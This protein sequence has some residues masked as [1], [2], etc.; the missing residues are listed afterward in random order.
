MD[1]EQKVMDATSFWND[2][3]AEGSPVDV[4][5]FLAI[6]L[7]RWPFLLLLAALSCALAVG[8][9]FLVRP[10]FT[11]HAVFLPPT[12]PSN[13][14]S[15]LALILRPPS[16]SIYLGLLVSDSVLTDVIER[17][18]L[19]RIYGARDIDM[20]RQS[21]RSA[22]TVTSDASGFVSLQ[23]TD[24]SPQLAQ[25]I[26]TNFLGALSRLNDR[27]AVSEAAQRRLI[28]QS[29]LEHAKNDLE[30]SE[31][32]LKQAQEKSGV[33]SP[34]AQIRSGL[35]AID[36]SRAQIRGMQV[37]LSA[38][39]QGQTE[40][41]PEVKRARSEIATEEGQLVRL[42]NASGGAQGA[43]LSA[44]QAPAVALKFVQLEREVKYNQVLF[45]V[46]AKQYENAKLQESSAAPGV[47]VV[48]LPQVPLHKSKPSRML[49]AVAGFCAGLFLGLIIV[50]VRNRL[51]VLRKDPARARSLETLASAIS[52]GQLRP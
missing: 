16:S 39:L 23:V 33:V 1:Q 13:S 24:K 28:F 21:L 2:P 32:A 27:L 25:V 52:A 42:E 10:Q 36:V 43:G 37:A 45:D 20:A 3:E 14:D 19:Q 38:L 35:S 49:F 12:P 9:S 15:T 30:A 46:M 48:D 31:V 17:T 50:F 11:S 22:I 5:S 29:E 44:V 18:D 40:Q 8:L 7:R 26:A 34:E 4:F 51:H 47:Q 41:S 6:F